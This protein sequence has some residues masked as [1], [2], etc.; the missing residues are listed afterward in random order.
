M[1]DAGV[2]AVLVGVITA[3]G[4]IVVAVIQLT[5]LRNENKADHAVVQ[6]QLATILNSV[7]RVDSKVDGVTDRLDKHIQEH[8][9]GAFGGV[10]TKRNSD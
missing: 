7:F 5:G 2:A 8:S 3:I 6:G 10:A 9:E 4:G 1:M